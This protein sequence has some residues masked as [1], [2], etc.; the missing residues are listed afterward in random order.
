MIDKN[1]E[2][3]SLLETGRIV[4]ILSLFYEKKNW[5]IKQKNRNNQL[6]TRNDVRIYSM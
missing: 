4:P 2:F 1:K 3:P 5:S 6:K